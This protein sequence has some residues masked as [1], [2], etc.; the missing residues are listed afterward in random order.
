MIGF[1]LTKEAAQAL[2]DWNRENYGRGASGEA[3]IT[4]PESIK[5]LQQLAMPG[6]SLNDVIVR[7][8]RQGGGVLSQ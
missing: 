8:Y 6:E 5:R 3:I 4:D 1:K 2:N 7:L